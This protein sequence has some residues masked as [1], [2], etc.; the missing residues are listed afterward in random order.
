MGLT[1]VGIAV[2]FAVGSV[3]CLDYRTYSVANI[4]GDYSHWSVGLWSGG[5]FTPGVYYH[6][7]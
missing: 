3:M 6:R 5:R 2:D 7:A 4:M 1:I